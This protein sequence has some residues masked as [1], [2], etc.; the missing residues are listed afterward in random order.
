MNI[1]RIVDGFVWLEDMEGTIV[2]DKVPSTFHI[3]LKSGGN[4]QYDIAENTTIKIASLTTRSKNV[5]VMYQ[6]NVVVPP[7]GP[8]IGGPGEEWEDDAENLH[9]APSQTFEGTVPMRYAQNWK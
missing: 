9:I 4:M 2:S 5:R 7:P 1:D 3:V 8:P 6:I